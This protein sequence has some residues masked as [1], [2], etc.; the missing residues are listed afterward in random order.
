MY[1][2]ATFMHYIDSF[3]NK[4]VKNLNLNIACAQAICHYRSCV[5]YHCKKCEYN[6]LTEEIKCFYE[7]KLIFN[8]RNSNRLDL[9]VDSKRNTGNKKNRETNDIELMNKI[10]N[11]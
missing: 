9:L 3:T 4:L 11:K 2:H 1:I 7:E 5:R 6:I 10:L 8:D